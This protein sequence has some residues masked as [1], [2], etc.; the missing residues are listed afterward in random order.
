M[1][2]HLFAGL[3]WRASLCINRC[4]IKETCGRTREKKTLLL[5]QLQKPEK[6]VFQH[7]RL[8]FCLCIM[9]TN[10]HIYIF[11]STSASCKRIYTNILIY[12]LYIYLYIF[13]SPSASCSSFFDV[14]HARKPNTHTTLHVIHCTAEHIQ[15]R[16]TFTIIGSSSTKKLFKEQVV[17]SATPS[18]TYIYIYILYTY[19]IIY[20]HIVYMYI[21]ED[22]GRG[23][24]KW[25][26]DDRIV[27]LSCLLRKPLWDRQIDVVRECLLLHISLHSYWKT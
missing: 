3:S 7:I 1:Y 11:P 23:K 12:I 19:C 9:Q 5:L 14:S 22:S 25:E 27:L 20:T 2:V 26:C 15:K 6:D 8:S 13:P 16:E 4:R 21:R 17:L 24:L 18:S 10:L